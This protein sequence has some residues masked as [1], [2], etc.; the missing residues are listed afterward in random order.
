MS[1][2]RVL[3]GPR[4]GPGGEGRGGGDGQVGGGAESLLGA[5]TMMRGKEGPVQVRGSRD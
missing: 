2:R 1:G 4:D 3:E 5:Y